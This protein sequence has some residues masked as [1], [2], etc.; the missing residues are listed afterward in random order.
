M[1]KFLIFLY[2]NQNSFNASITIYNGAIVEEGGGVKYKYNVI[3]FLSKNW[4]YEFA[5]NSQDQ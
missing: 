1:F 4:A 5:S 2:Q 3:L